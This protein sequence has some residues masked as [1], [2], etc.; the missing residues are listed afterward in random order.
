[1]SFAPL[2]W[3]KKTVHIVFVELV[4]HPGKDGIRILSGFLCLLWGWE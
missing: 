3:A 4:F 1:M 2:K